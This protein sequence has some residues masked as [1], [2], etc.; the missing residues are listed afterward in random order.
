MSS[1][2][3]IKPFRW[4]VD[5]EN[6]L[7]DLIGNGNADLSSEFLDELIAS[8]ARIIGFAD[9]SILYFV[10]R[11]PENYFDFLSGIY[12]EQKN[13]LNNFQLFQFSGKRHTIQELISKYAFDLEVFKGYM[14]Q[15]GLSPSQILGRKSNTAFVDVVYMGDTFEI[16]FE[17]LKKWSDDIKADWNALRQKIRIVGITERTKNSPNTW[18]WQQQV[19]WIEMV[20][21]TR[22]KNVSVTWD[23]WRHIANEQ[24]KTTKSF[25]P[26]RWSN[27][28]VSEPLREAFNLEGLKLAR[29][30]YRA[31]LEKGSKTNLRKQLVKQ[32]EVEYGWFKEYIKVLPK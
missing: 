18:R 25:Y 17:I 20:G 29:T 24:F 16:L 12:S 23:F 5:R 27:N 31:G 14:T 6:E 22:V 1:D 9:N 19:D 21:Q 13:L 15:I 4:N 7:G 3:N 8:S 26:D 11:S 30:I 10:G 32:K 28:E 2:L